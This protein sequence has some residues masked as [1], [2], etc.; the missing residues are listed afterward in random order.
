MTAVDTLG[1]AGAVATLPDQ[2]T[3]AL[4][5]AAAVDLGA[6][7]GAAVANIAVCGMG[8]SGISGDVLA[9]AGSHDLSVPVTVLKQYRVPRFVGPGTL[10]FA[11]SYSGG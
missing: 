3:E 8:G 2:F 4:S 10:F 7:S 9:T 6:V 1:F 11:M 5:T